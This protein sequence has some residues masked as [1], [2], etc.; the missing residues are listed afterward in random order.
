MS[1]LDTSKDLS[2]L[3]SHQV[4]LTPEAIAVDD[5]TTKYTYSQLNEK[6]E[7]LAGILGARGV[8]RDVLVGV[9]LPRSAD[10]IIACLA[11][12]RAGGAFLVLELAYPAELLSDVLDD[13]NPAVI[14]T[15]QSEVGKFPEGTPL[16]VLNEAS[17]GVNG[18]GINGHA[19]ALPS[20]NDL[21]RLAFVAYS[22][23]T[24]GKPKG[25][26]NP[27][28]A[29]VLS[30]DLRFQVCDQT[31]GDRV[32]C[33]V[34]LRLGNPA[35]ASA[36]SDCRSSTRR[37]QLRS[38]RARR[39]A[40][41]SLHVTE[42]LMTPTLLAAVLSRHPHIGSRLPELKKLWLNGRG[43]H[44]RFGATS[45][46]GPSQMPTAQRLQRLRDT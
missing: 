45:N 24:T 37:N 10:Y 19:N 13:A 22:S 29:A 25:I 26:A 4:T 1:V 14:V 11:S 16:L 34:F 43:R 21:D 42:T 6:V 17:N 32:A 46:E 33:N 27:H 5:G 15:Y 35:T 31:P 44:D 23:G 9:L 30:Y 7:D 38:G 18:H 12:L 28:R 8:G 39:Y 3:F 36:R 2:A 40:L 41:L 20:S